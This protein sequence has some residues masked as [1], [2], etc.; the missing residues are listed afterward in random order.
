M[1]VRS[2]MSALLVL[3]LATCLGLSATERRVI[4]TW[5]EKS[6]DGTEFYVLRSDHSYAFVGG[7]NHELPRPV[8]V[9]S[10]SWRIEGDDLI[11]DCTR[12]EVSGRVSGRPP[13]RASHRLKVAEF[14][15]FHKR[16]PPISYEMP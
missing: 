4:G 16:H 15:K 6:F 5:K 12:A 9:C 3:S 1:L 8:L 7:P 10:G 2:F 13:E 14:L 11:L